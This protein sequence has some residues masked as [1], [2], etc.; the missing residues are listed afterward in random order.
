[1]LQIVR[2]EEARVRDV[3]RKVDAGKFSR[4]GG[5]RASEESGQSSGKEP[6]RRK[7]VESGLAT[8]RSVER[9]GSFEAEAVQSSSANGGV[10]QMVEAAEVTAAGRNMNGGEGEGE[11][12]GSGKP[13]QRLAINLDL[14]L[15]RAR[16]LR[17]KG[18]YNQ[19]V[20]LLQ[21]VIIWQE[22]K[23]VLVMLVYVSTS[24]SCNS[25]K[26]VQ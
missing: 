15:Y 11:A 1:V 9:D 6:Y 26:G 7:L 13:Y 10:Y 12:A 19:A 25:C 3:W 22:I 23:V 14:E 24:D 4:A 17:Q 18:V 5:Q 20:T 16:I 8:G 2:V 21:Q